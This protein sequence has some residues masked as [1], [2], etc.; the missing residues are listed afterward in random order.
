M[1]EPSFAAVVVIHDSAPELATLL[2]SLEGRVDP[3]PE[4]V[5]VDTG[6]TDGGAELARERGARVVELPHNPGFGAANNAGVARTSAAVTALLN[7][8]IELLD[9]GL[10]SLVATV[11]ER[12]VLV[13]P[14]LI[15]ADGTVERSAHP[16]PG[17]L[18]GLV[19]AVVHPR[20]L[21]RSIRL[22]ADPWRTER[23]R[24]VGWAVAAC[25]VARTETLSTLG[26]FDPRAF[27]FYEDMDLCL[28]ARE[29]GVPT[30][31]D[32]DV[33]VR[34]IG[35]HATEAAYG[36]EPY[37]LMATRRR[38]VVKER[39]GR[40]A[41]ALDDAAQALTFATRASARRLLGGSG[42]REAAQLRAV[43]GARRGADPLDIQ[44]G[45]SRRGD[46]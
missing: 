4:L 35:G 45:P 41:L 38:Q 40:S 14:R 20:A 18:A 26:P 33:R 7:P 27:L 6:S 42:G 23:P 13:V 31:I 16:K 2:S 32:P 10:V 30:V 39:L 43:L 3:A 37:E 8:D 22:R 28:R 36:G 1:S 24:R 21:P 19:P 34:H 29:A 5:V 11:R 17:Q 46:G 9:S 25:L 15:D 44:D 12:N